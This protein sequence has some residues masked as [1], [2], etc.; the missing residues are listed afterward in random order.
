[1][2]EEAELFARIACV[3]YGRWKRVLAI[4]AVSFTAPSE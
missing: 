3:D 4:A 2:S 1:M